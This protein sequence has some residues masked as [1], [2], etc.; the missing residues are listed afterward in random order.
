MSAHLLVPEVAE[1]LRQSKRFVL[2]ELRRKNLRGS[3]FGGQ[4]HVAEADL[5]TYIDAHANV[6]PVGKA[7]A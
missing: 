3:Y 2:E 6:R 7:T 5:K 4:W 1:R